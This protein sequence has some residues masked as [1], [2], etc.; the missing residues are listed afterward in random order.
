QTGAATSVQSRFAAALAALHRSQE[1]VEAGALRC[2]GEREGSTG[3]RVQRRRSHDIAVVHGD[4]YVEVDTVRQAQHDIVKLG[5]AADHARQVAGE[6]D[7]DAI[8]GEV[9]DVRRQ[10]IAGRIAQ[11]NAQVRFAFDVDAKGMA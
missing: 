4:F 5:I 11:V 10:R 6:T 2:T 9:D 1:L 3:P 8:G 7:L